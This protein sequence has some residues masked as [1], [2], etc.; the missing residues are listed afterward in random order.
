MKRVAVLGLMAVLVVWGALGQMARPT[1]VYHAALSGQGVRGTVVVLALPEGLEVFVYLEGLKPGS[2]AYANHIHFNRAGNA[3]CREQRGPDPRPDL[4]GGRRQRSG[5]GL[6]AP[7]GGPVA[8]GLHLRERP[9]Q[10]PCPGGREHRLRRPERGEG[11]LLR[12][13]DA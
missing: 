12:R 3:N 11:A 2:G 7:A 13:R 4:P 10:H 9:R 8:Q 6:H 5:R 1:E